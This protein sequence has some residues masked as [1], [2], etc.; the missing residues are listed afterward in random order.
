VLVTTG[1]TVKILDFGLAKLISDSQAETLTQAGQAFGTVLYM[2]PE[3][4]QGASV[5]ARSDLWSFGVLAYELL[6]RTSP[7]RTDSST[8]TVA[9]I[10]NEDPA[11]LA[12]VPGIPDW[13]AQLVSELLQKNPSKRLQT[14]GEVL[15]RLEHVERALADLSAAISPTPQ[16]R[17][18]SMRP[19]LI[20]AAI[21]IGALASGALAWYLVV[22]VGR[23]PPAPIASSHPALRVVASSGMRPHWE[24]GR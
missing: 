6:A 8:T 12:G 17:S 23:K 3:Q 10:L 19:R 2:S 5:D 14:A 9:R 15:K 1:G 20:A 16:P 22:G 18:P 13:L 21:V 7:F 11:S 4:L 24:R